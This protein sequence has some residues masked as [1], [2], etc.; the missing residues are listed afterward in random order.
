MSYHRYVSTIQV[1]HRQGSE[2]KN[3]N[4]F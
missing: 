2:N 1:G 4:T 3:T